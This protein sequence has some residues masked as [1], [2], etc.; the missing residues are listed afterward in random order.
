M[1]LDSLGVRRGKEVLLENCNL[2]P[3]G[4]FSAR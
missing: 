3:R 2:L 4:S 1:I